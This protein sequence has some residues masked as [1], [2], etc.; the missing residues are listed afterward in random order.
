MNRLKD[1]IARMEAKLGAG[2]H[3]THRVER[4]DLKAL[5]GLA[6][7]A[8]ECAGDPVGAQCEAWRDGYETGAA[9]HGGRG[10]K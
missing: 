10:G 7:A 5:V 3:E 2:Y 1:M 9:D 6:K 4:E 8:L